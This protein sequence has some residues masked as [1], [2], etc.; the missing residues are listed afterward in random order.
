VQATGNDRNL[1][2]AVGP[3]PLSGQLG[4]GNLYQ[5]P[6]STDC[7]S[8][9]SNLRDISG[10]CWSQRAVV[11]VVARLWVE[12]RFACRQVGNLVF[13]YL[14]SQFEPNPEQKPFA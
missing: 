11:G 3:G 13:C 7:Q 5:L 4:P 2:T 14:L 12:L 8:A 1:C 10:H 9:R 6:P